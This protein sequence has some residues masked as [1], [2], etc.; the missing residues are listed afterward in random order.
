MV[1]GV[2]GAVEWWWR[3]HA[4]GIALAPFGVAFTVGAMALGAVVPKDR[5]SSFD[6]FW[7]MITV[8]LFARLGGD[9]FALVSGSSIDPIYLWDFRD[10][11]FHVRNSLPLSQ[12]VYTY[13][14]V[15]SRS[16][17]AEQVTEKC[18]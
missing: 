6:F 4:V 3:E 14:S 1:P 13:Q 15:S 8:N 9:G 11:D 7:I 16:L 17:E 10:L 2:A 12:L 5:T 18:S